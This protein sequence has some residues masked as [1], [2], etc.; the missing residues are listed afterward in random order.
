MDGSYSAPVGIYDTLVR[1]ADSTYTLS[2]KNQ[3]VWTFRADG[4]LSRIAEP[5]R[6]PDQSGL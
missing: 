4:W 5:Q 2:R 6:Q 3:S 1:N